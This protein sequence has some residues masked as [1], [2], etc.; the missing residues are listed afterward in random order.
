MKKILTSILAASAVLSMA[1]PANAALQRGTQAPAFRTN[2][3]LAGKTFSFDLARELRKG[4]VVVYFFPKAFTQ[5][6]TLEARAFAEAMGDFRAAGAQVIGLS[7]D[8]IDTLKR[9]STEECRDA[10]PV[11]QASKAIIDGYDVAFGNGEMS[12]RTS[13]VIAQDGRVVMVHSDL[14]WREHVSRSLAAV[15]ALKS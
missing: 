10:F 4:P 14:D 9:F 13:Y 5:G 1:I 8:D 7:G 6:C 3:A 2:G 12:N 15:R 11:G